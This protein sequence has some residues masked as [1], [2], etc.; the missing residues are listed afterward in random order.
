MTADK[1]MASDKEARGQ[2]MVEFALLLPLIILI[3]MGIFAFALIFNSQ[4]TVTNAA[5]A[6]ARTGS[7]VDYSSYNV[8]GHENAAIYNAVVTNMSW[9][10]MDRVE[11]IT[12][13]QPASDGS[14][15]SRKDVL[16]K[17]GNL[18]SG[19][20][21]NAYRLS[22]TGL[23]VEIV[24]NEPVWIPIINLIT[25]DEIEIRVRESRRIE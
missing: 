18:V 6:A 22:N 20:F 21:T 7:V 25:G 9:L 17:D 24:Y 16:D 15:S 12:I 1:R 13:Y 4:I 10:G 14:I 23:G 19:N 8:N 3:V 11:S 5:A 2:T